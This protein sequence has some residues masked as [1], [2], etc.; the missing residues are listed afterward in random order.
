MLRDWFLTTLGFATHLQAQCIAC[1][2][3]DFPELFCPTSTVNPVDNGIVAS[4]IALKFS[5]FTASS[6]MGILFCSIE[7]IYFSVLI[8]GLFLVV[9]PSS[10]WV[11]ATPRSSWSSLD[12]SQCDI[13]HPDQSSFLCLILIPSPLGRLGRHRR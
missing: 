4:F 8:Q 5:I 10:F 9:G 6:F 7:S 11:I 1:N 2:A 12:R 13:F 3:D